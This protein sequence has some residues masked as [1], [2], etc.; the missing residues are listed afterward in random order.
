[1]HF[2]LCIL[3]QFIVFKILNNSEGFFYNLKIINYLSDE[4]L[5]LKRLLFIIL[6]SKR[7]FEYDSLSSSK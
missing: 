6:F 1:M 4:V 7:P 3:N 2:A 5:I